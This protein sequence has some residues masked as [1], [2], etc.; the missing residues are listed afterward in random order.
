MPID[1]WPVISET[2]VWFSGRRGLSQTELLRIIGVSLGDI[3]KSCAMSI[4]PEVLWASMEEN[5]WKKT[6]SCYVS[7]RELGVSQ[8]SEYGWSRSGKFALFAC[9]RDV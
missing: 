6:V 1:I 7:W 9:S 8:S 2:I 4:L 3:S 5:T